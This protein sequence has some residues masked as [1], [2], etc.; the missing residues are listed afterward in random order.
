MRAAVPLAWLLLV[1]LL[2]GCQVIDDATAPIDRDRLVED[3]TKQLQRG[4]QVRYQAEYQL[5]GGQEALVAQQVTPSRTVYEYPGGLLIV[6]EDEQTTC[7][8][9]IAPV[10]CQISAKNGQLTA[11][12][13]ATKKGL[14]T[15]PVV[16]DLLR[17]TT[18]QPSSTVKGH[19]T[20]IAGLQASCLEVLGLTETITG[21]FTACVTADGVLAS[22]TGTVEGINVDQ[23]L[24]H[25][26]LRNPDAT[27]FAVPKDAD[28]V[29]LRQS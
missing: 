11:Y 9:S 23:A 20:T 1:S 24:A 26:V 3:M 25:L 2:T 7:D 29:D 8:V 5:A 13:E 10:K 16:N 18:L 4:S 22:F 21:N 15:A 12:A 27:H 28:V 14:V 19:D 17:V 6:G